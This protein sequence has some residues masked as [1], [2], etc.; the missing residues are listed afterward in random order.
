MDDQELGLTL[1]RIEQKQDDT[2]DDIKELRGDVEAGFEKM[3]T[4]Q[5][6]TESW[7]DKV[8]G[9]AKTVSIICVGLGVIAGLV[10]VFM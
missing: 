2:R 1:G 3:N 7:I 8:K 6:K 9:G 10:R 5:K 4:R